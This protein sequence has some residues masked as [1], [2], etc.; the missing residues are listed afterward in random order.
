MQKRIWITWDVTQLSFHVCYNLQITVERKQNLEILCMS[1][2]SSYSGGQRGHFGLTPSP[3][4]YLTWT[5]IIYL[6]LFSLSLN[7]L[8]SENNQS[9]LPQ[10]TILCYQLSATS[11]RPRAGKRKYP[12]INS[13]QCKG[14]V[15]HALTFQN[16]V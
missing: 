3:H 7:Q 10:M 6:T 16:W 9:R 13:D 15:F 4:V 11:H 1:S 12:A 14:R 5:K 2:L 8:P